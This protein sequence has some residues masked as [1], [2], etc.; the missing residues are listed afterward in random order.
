MCGVGGV[1]WH[2]LTRHFLA[3]SDVCTSQRMITRISS[4]TGLTACD[5]KFVSL[6]SLTDWCDIGCIAWHILARHFLAKSDVCT[7]QRM[8]TR[9]S[10]STGLTACDEKFVSLLSPTDLCDVGGIA[11][12]ILT[13]HFL[14]KID[15]YTSQRMITRISSSTGLTACDEKFVSLL[16]PTDWCDIGC[17][18]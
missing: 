12:H 8:I 6:L 4:S 17:I 3:K 15:V 14:A 10:S 1:A 5:E 13:R 16:S 11:W 7:S 9:I 2:I 18:A